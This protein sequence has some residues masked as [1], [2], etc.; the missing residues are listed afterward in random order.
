MHTKLIAAKSDD[1]SLEAEIHVVEEIKRSLHVVV[2]SVPHACSAIHAHLYVCS[3]VHTQI[4][5]KQENQ[6]KIK[7]WNL[8]NKFIMLKSWISS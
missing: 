5:S 1:L 2:F 6:I 3:Q 4:K 7:N 8:N